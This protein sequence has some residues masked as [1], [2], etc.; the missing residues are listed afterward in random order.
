MRSGAE[1]PPGQAPATPYVSQARN[2]GRGRSLTEF[3]G[4]PRPPKARYDD[5]HKRTYTQL[6]KGFTIVSVVVIV[7]ILALMI[8]G[9]GQHGPGRHFSSDGSVTGPRRHFGT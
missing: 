5:G 8:F 4:A 7:M 6:G 2:R 1:R 9:G 3:S